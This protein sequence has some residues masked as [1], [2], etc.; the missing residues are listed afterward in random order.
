[1]A[2]LSSREAR[3]RVDVSPLVRVFLVISG[4]ITL[5]VHYTMTEFSFLHHFVLWLVL[6]DKAV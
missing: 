5:L 4:P 2:R 3:K 1:M 6:Q